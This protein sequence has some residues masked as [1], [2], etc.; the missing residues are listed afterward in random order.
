[1]A[2]IFASSGLRYEVGLTYSQAGAIPDFP[3]IRPSDYLKSLVRTGDFT[4]LLGGHS[5]ESSKTTLHTFWTRYKDQF[6]AHEVFSDPVKSANLHRC[7][8]VYVHG[9]EGTTYKKKGVLVI[10]F[11]SPIGHG[12]RHS[13]NQ[14]PE[15]LNDAGIP[16]NLL[17]TS[18]QSRFL[19]AICPKDTWFEFKQTCSCDILDDF[20]GFGDRMQIY[21]GF[22][23]CYIYMF[24]NIYIYTVI[25]L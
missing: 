18:L 12:S 24:I 15:T 14:R 20:M 17:R 6:P 16:M 13:P 11:Q 10:A 19:T 21:I 25:T 4:K 22:G 8:P 5:L 2:Q 23:D 1:M 3:W 7:V 9:D